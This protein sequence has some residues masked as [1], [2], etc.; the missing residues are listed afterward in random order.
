MLKISHQ[1][2]LTHFIKVA[3]LAKLI[4]LLVLVQFATPLRGQTPP[5][6]L[7]WLNGDRLPVVPI[8]ADKST[9]TVQSPLFRDPLEIDFGVL[10]R[11]SFERAAKDN[12]K[13]KS[14]YAIQMTDGQTM[15]TDILA[16][17]DETLT[18][19]S[20][21]TGEVELDRSRIGSIVNL[22]RTETVISG[23]FDLDK[24]DA[25]RGEKKHWKVNDR[26][27]LESTRA[28]IHL[29]LKSKLPESCLIAVEIQWSKNLDF[30]LALGVP[31][32]ARML[33][34]VPRLESW[35]DSI[36]FSFGDDFEI[37]IE[38]LDESEK[39][40]KF[41]IHWDQSSKQVVIHDE[42]GKTL[43]T[44]DMKDLKAKFEPGIYIDNKSGDL[45]VSS[46]AIRSSGSGF[47][48]TQPSVQI[49]D[50]PALNA[51]L[52]SFDGEV[53]LAENADGEEIEIAE[54]N[55]GATFLLNEPTDD[56]ITGDRIR[57]TDG[58]SLQGELLSLTDDQANFRSNVSKEP[59][60][61]KLDRAAS[62]QFSDR[63]ALQEAKKASVHRLFNSAGSMQG[64]MELGSGEAGD[65]IRWRVVGGKQP[66]PFST[67]IDK[68]GSARVVL[69]KRKQQ[70]DA[71]SKWRDTLYLKNRDMVPCTITSMDEESVYVDSFFA[72]KSIPESLI[73]AAHFLG[74]GD[75]PAEVSLNDDVWVTKAPGNR[76]VKIKNDIMKLTKNSKAF[77]PW[78][79]SRGG[80][81]FDL[82]WPEEMYGVLK[83]RMGSDDE[84]ISKQ[85]VSVMLWGQYAGAGSL[86]R[87]Q[88]N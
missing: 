40:L 11:L 6:N 84:T 54:D 59:M 27:Q 2:K 23:A 67:S 73:K 76:K 55:F 10:D 68:R 80:F 1:L 79:L 48:A 69:Q 28:N 32:S 82:D 14:P 64:T 70:T 3:W 38:E 60:T 85:G 37:V 62:I 56:A 18:V 4:C 50:K 58:F 49:T 8:Q 13:P 61:L 45:K 36:V 25:K 22:D 29:F 77:H 57:F 87:E 7:K 66:V 71:D 20:D 43:A 86:T 63:K 42:R 47:D 31:K 41:L 19:T 74:G 53:W 21:R 39:R 30:S 24:W 12:G 65:V 46:L 15:F 83:L 35:Q 17:G 9:L 16:L 52:K 75:T 88:P 81:E 51:Q 5:A 72:N 78:L 26:G 44:V 34:E 33:D